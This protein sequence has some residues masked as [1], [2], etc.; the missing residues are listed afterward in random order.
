MDEMS[1]RE[2]ILAAL[3]RQ[4]VDR[5]PFVPLIDT[6]SVLDMPA[7]VQQAMQAGANEGYWQGILA[8]VREI[9]CDI[10]LRHVYVT[11]SAGGAPHLNGFGRFESPVVTSSRMDGSLLVETL[12]TPVG[13]LT[14]TWG[15][16]DAHGWIPHPVKH[17][18]NNLEELK[19]FTYAVEH[20]SREKP[21]PDFENYI[22][23]EQAL[24]QGGLATT[25]FLNTPLMDL[26][27]T[28]WGLENT[29]Y[30]LHDYPA[31]VE[32]VLEG[33]HQVQRLTVERIAESPAP[34]VIEYENTSSTL[35]SPAV[36]KRYCLPILNEYADIIK[37]SGKIFLVHMCGK[38]KAFQADLAAARFDGVADISPLPTGNFTLDEAAASLPGK[39]VIGGIDATTFIEPDLKQVEAKIAALIEKVKPY[40]GVLLGSADT[41]PRGTSLETFR[42]IQH[43]VGTAGSYRIPDSYRPGEFLASQTMSVGEASAVSAD[44]PA[45]MNMHLVLQELARRLDGKRPE[46][47]GTIKFIVTGD[48][49]YRLFIAQG[50]CCL[51]ISDGPADASMAGNPKNLLALFAG[52]LNAM[53]AFMTRKIKFDGDLKLL[54]VLTAAAE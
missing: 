38:L 29:Y 10:M 11:K 41:A 40:R 26:I 25:S 53:A 19:I 12:E 52:K 36:F 16:T 24:G 43:L 37:S 31:E 21:E 46:V 4:P 35:L 1:S 18:V 27:E 2:R 14:G 51:E 9:R 13:T 39:A 45:E 17:L 15:F 42:L 44:V 54:G 7:H 8:A 49:I 34:V 30:L 20:L 47:T 23:A 5:I 32:A 3:Q 22:K 28:C 48:Q 50:K 6:Y 33:L